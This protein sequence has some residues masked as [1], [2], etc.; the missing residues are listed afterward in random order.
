[1]TDIPCAKCNTPASKLHESSKCSATHYVHSELG[2]AAPETGE[3]TEN[4]TTSH[5]HSDRL[6]DSSL[7]TDE[8]SIDTKNPTQETTT[9]IMVLLIFISTAVDQ[10]SENHSPAEHFQSTSRD[11]DTQE[12]MNTC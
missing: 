2:T 1:M 6:R 8:Q 10:L 11:P 5:D 12:K 3:P 7:S 4:S 9:L